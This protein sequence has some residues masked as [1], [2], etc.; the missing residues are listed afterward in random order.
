M[1]INDIHSLFLESKGVT[2]D[3]R[4]IKRDTIFFALKGDNF[5]GNTYAVEALEQ[6]A[7]YAIIDDKDFASGDSR[8]ILVADALK[9]LQDLAHI[10][11]KHLDIP[12]LALTGSN[13][14]T[15]TKELI[16]SVLSKKFK[17]VATQGNLNNHIGVPLTLLSMTSD[18]EFGI[19]EM[20]AN[21]I[22]EIEQ[23]TE[24]AAPDFGYITNF[25]KAHLE[26]FGGVAGV[27]KGKSELYTYLIGHKGT[28]FLNLDDPIQKSKIGQT[29]SYTFSQS[30]DSDVHF[31]YKTANPFASLILNNQHLKSNLIGQYNTIN[32]AAAAAI[33]CYFKINT[34][35]I[36][37]AIESYIPSN[38]RSQIIEREEQTIILDAYN[39]NPSSME[40]ALNNFA[41]LEAKSKIAFLGDMFELGESAVE[42]HQ[43][44]ADLARNLDLENIVF[45]GENFKKIKTK[46]HQ[47]ENIKDLEEKGLPAEISYL[48][49]QATILIKG[50]RGMKLEG[51]LDLLNN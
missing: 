43:Y 13:G 18:T 3:T 19:V 29:H 35:D 24:I 12:I 26:G 7:S 5:N 8:I 16:N 47:F 14:K 51:I 41:G 36:I 9:T 31:T 40:A 34:E 45:L 30:K 33:G 49:P 20:G 21:H 44:I 4:K 38:N 48:L 39:A 42:E 6:G 23:L 32:I 25:G 11:R 15:T 17:T 27:I 46:N 22:G 10:H 50:S 2:T 1:E 28:L 37:N